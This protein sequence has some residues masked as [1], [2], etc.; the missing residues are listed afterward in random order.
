LLLY[1]Q[2]SILLLRVAVAELENTVVAVVLAAIA[3]LS[4]ANHQVVE[5]LPNLPLLYLAELL[6][7]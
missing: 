5:P 2:L 7:R 1:I 3:L 4:S 6:T